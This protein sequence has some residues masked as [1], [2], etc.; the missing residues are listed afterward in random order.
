MF[1]FF[2]QTPNHF[3]HFLEFEL[4]RASFAAAAGTPLLPQMVHFKLERDIQKPL[5]LTEGCGAERRGPGGGPAG[6]RRR[7]HAASVC[8]R[9]PKKKKKRL[10]THQPRPANFSHPEPCVGINR[11][12]I[13]EIVR[14]EHK[15]LGST[16]IGQFPACIERRDWFIAVFFFFFAKA[17]GTPRTAGTAV[18]Q[19]LFWKQGGGALSAGPQWRRWW[20]LAFPRTRPLE[21]EAD[22]AGSPAKFVRKVSHTAELSSSGWVVVGGV[23][24]SGRSQ[25]LFAGRLRWSGTQGVRLKMRGILGTII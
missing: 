1:Q 5:C 10:R 12:P 14:P 8:Q 11:S 9:R 15:H 23:R 25:L 22:D 17:A 24:K 2:T 13:C 16:L 21:Q 6:A 18:P 20:R 3:E 7:R 4:R 19:E